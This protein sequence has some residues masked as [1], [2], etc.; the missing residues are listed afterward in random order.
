MIWDGQSNCT[1]FRYLTSIETPPVRKQGD[2]VSPK[3][4]RVAQRWTDMISIIG[5]SSSSAKSAFAAI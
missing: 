5:R 1:C 2:P 3:S 4:Q